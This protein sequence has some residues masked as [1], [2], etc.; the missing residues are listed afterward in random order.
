M[1]NRRTFLKGIGGIGLWGST[2]LP[3]ARGSRFL[4]PEIVRKRTKAR[5]QRRPIIWNNDGS[6]IQSIAYAGGK[7][8]NPL[9]SVEQFWGGTLR[10]LEGTPVETILYCAHTNEP[11]WEFPKKYIEVLGPNPVQHVVDFARKHQKEFFYSIRM[12]DVPLLALRSEIRILV[13]LQAG[14]S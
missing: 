13:L 5:Q 8:P 11:D 3:G 12:N 9:E 10:F 4:Q 7:W 6:D 2:P 14:Q 1:K